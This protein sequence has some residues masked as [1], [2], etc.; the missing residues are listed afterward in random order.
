M[1]RIRDG[2]GRWV[3]RVE[4]VGMGTCALCAGRAAYWCA[5]GPLCELH[6]G[7]RMAAVGRVPMAERLTCGAAQSQLSTGAGG[8]DKWEVA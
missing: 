6:A 1:Y 7:Q 4:P 3:G 5:G 2:H 8:V